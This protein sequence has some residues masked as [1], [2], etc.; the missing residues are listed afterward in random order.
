MSAPDA[1]CVTGVGMVT[2]AGDGREATWRRVRAGLPTAV[3]E[4]EGQPPRLVCRVPS[5]GPERLG[6]L[7]ARRPDR[8]VQLA[9]L[10]AR[11][12]VADAGHDPA[13]WDGARVA[14]V[15]GAGC[16][17]AQTFEAQHR[18]LSEAGQYGMSAFSVPGSLGSALAAQLTMELRA[19]GPG[20][21]VNTACASGAT[22]ICTA[23]DLLALDRCDIAVAG[24]AEAPLTPFYLAGYDRMRAL[25]R[26]FDDPAGALR[27]FDAGRDGFVLGEGAGMVVLERERDARA[28]GARPRALVAG[29]GTASD[30]HHVVRPDPAGRGLAA[31]VRQALRA[32][33]AAPGDVAHVNAHGAGTRLGDRVEADVLAAVLPHRPPVTSTKAVTGHLLGA[34]GAVEAALTVLSVERRTIPP[35]AN[36]TAPAPGTRLDLVTESR[37]QRLPLALSVSTGFGGHNAALAFAEAS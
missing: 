31:A 35:T 1:V 4:D 8:C 10:A 7:A 2:P 20:C 18:L 32:A 13:R 28:R 9:L 24:G 22:A 14:V 26:R 25:S 27:P 29:Q 12:A 21:T 11:D 36:L 34:A 6:G 15:T 5:F 17:G 23:L 30:A 33:G 3:L 37:S 16:C 19:T